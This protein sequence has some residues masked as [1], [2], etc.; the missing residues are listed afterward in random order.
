MKAVNHSFS[1]KKG[2]V[3]ALPIVHYNMEMAAQVRLAFS[4]IQ[5]ECLA[6]EL[7]EPMQEQLFHAASRLPDISVVVTHDKND[8]A[9]YYMCEPCDAAFE[10]IRCAMENQ[11]PCFCIDLDVFQYP[12]RADR[13]PDPYAITRLG[14]QPYFAAYLNSQHP[15]TELRLDED[16]HREMYMAKRL[17]ELSLQYESILFI[18]GMYHVENVLKLMD[19]DDFPPLRT[20]STQRGTGLHSNR[21]VLSRGNG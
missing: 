19:K 10:G 2:N 16:W 20:R 14:L 21:R 17:K 11:L 1:L 7:A 15:E 12:E 5:P 18:G 13:V 9:S 4:S 8:D 6:V 3:Y